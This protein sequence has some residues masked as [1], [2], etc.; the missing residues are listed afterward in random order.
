MKFKIYV[1]KRINGYTKKNLEFLESLG[2][3]RKCLSFQ[4]NVFYFYEGIESFVILVV[5]FS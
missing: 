1:Y 4:D 3:N 2:N 5:D